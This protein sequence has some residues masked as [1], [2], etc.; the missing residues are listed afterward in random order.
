MEVDPVPKGLMNVIFIIFYGSQFPR[1]VSST[2][3]NTQILDSTSHPPTSMLPNV[4]LD[5]EIDSLDL[6]FY[7]ILIIIFYKLFFFVL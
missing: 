3:P 4:A 7:K 5:H 2:I 1:E 6:I